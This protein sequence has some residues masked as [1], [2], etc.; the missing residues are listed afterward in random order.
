MSDL[1]PSIQSHRERIADLDR[2]L[3][4]TL[5]E[6]I[7]LVRSLWVLKT[8]QALPYEDP[9]QEARV[10]ATLQAANPGPLSPEGLEALFRQIIAWSKQEAG[11]DR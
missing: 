6:R 9:D 2:Q 10:L 1:D 7:R 11:A 8:Q 3:L 4:A 5:N